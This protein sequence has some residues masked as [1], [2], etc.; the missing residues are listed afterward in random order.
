MS[1]KKKSKAVEWPLNSRVEIIWADAC[2]LNGWTDLEDIKA[3]RPV[4]ARSVGYLIR[5]DSESVTL[6]GTQASDSCGCQGITIP[7]SWIRKVILLKPTTASSLKAL[8][9]KV[10]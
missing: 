1:T 8:W 4:Q 10:K 2:G 9:H 3:H 5:A 7:F 6:I